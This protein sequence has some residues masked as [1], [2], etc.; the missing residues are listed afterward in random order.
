MLLC[1]EWY[2]LQSCKILSH[3]IPVTTRDNAKTRIHYDGSILDMLWGRWHLASIGNWRGEMTHSIKKHSFDDRRQNKGLWGRQD[4]WWLATQGLGHCSS[5]YMMKV[6]GEGV[7]GALKQQHWWHC[8]PLTYGT[9]YL[10]HAYGLNFNVQNW[11]YL[12][13]GNYMMI[14]PIKN[15]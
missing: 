3:V 14:D 1:A 10:L 13:R 5:W 4:D 8:L 6:F 11:W 12:H 2:Y 9:Q 7:G 15:C